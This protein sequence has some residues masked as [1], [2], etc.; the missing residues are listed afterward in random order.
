ME[1]LLPLL[2]HRIRLCEELLGLSVC[3]FLL[4]CLFK[5]I[6]LGLN[7][8]TV[9]Q[10]GMSRD[11]C[12]YPLRGAALLFVSIQRPLKQQ[13]LPN[14]P[15]N[16]VSLFSSATSFPVFSLKGTPS[17]GGLPVSPPHSP[18]GHS[19][20]CDFTDATHSG[21]C[22]LKTCLPQRQSSF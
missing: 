6:P 14:T 20:C 3:V 22:G 21:R 5:L 2:P 11:I 15:I 18:T 7:W 16:Q 9:D 1:G 13:V 8:E 10:S 17:A 12:F 4:L 19:L